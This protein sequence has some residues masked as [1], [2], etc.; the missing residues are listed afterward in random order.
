MKENMDT[1]SA[2]VHTGISAVSSGVALF[3]LHDAQ[4]IVTFTA[5]AFAVV[6]GIMA[7]RYYWYASEEKRKGLKGK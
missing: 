1:L 5:S 3:T 2:K 7:A 6:S 4:A